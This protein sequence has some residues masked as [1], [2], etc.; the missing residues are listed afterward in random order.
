MLRRLAKP[1]A[2]GR[3]PDDLE[4]YGTVPR[5]DHRSTGGLA[6]WRTHLTVSF[7]VDRP[8]RVFKVAVSLDTLAL[9]GQ[10]LE[11]LDRDPAFIRVATV[12]GE[13]G[14]IWVRIEAG[15]LAVA[16]ARTLSAAAEAT[17]L[18]P[19]GVVAARD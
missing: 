2:K 1:P 8:D 11:A 19:V 5:H 13:P 16:I 7:T 9:T 12:R 3:P 18:E 10:Q 14:L 4:P 6:R 17:G 15:S